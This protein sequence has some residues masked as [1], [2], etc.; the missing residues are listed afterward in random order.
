MK[1][2][3]RSGFT[4]VE[5]L[6]VIAIIGTLIGLLIPAVM[7]ARQAAYRTNTAIE[8]NQLDA[9]CKQFYKNYGFFPPSQ[10]TLPPSNPVDQ[11]IIK[12]MFPRIDATVM[13]T[14]GTWAPFS[15]T[16]TGDACLVFFLGGLSQ[17]PASNPYAPMG[18]N[19]NPKDP[20]VNGG[21]GWSGPLY[22]FPARLAK[23]ASGNWVLLD[24]Y[25][26]MPYAYFSPARTNQYAAGDCP[27]VPN[28]PYLDANGFPLNPTTFQ[29]ISAGFDT[30]FGPGGANL[31]PG[32]GGPPQVAGQDDQANFAPGGGV[33]SNY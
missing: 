6:V 25:G 31:V 28:G 21:G 7:K 14:A 13:S 20:S 16:L 12:R 8:I 4:L 22:T 17:T 33:L 18:F 29:I 1:T 11:A 27:L 3:R 30:T 23:N 26:K 9:A 2:S 15:G 32:G 5:L 24:Y 10:I 19:L